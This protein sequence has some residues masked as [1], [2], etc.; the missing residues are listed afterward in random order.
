MRSGDDVGTGAGG[1]CD[2][3]GGTLT[4]VFPAD[5]GSGARRGEDACGGL[6]TGEG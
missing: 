3:N 2:G 4:G 5:G 6:E 1:F